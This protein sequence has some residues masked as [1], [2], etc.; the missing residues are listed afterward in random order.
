MS[1]PGL[2]PAQHEAGDVSANFVWAGATTVM[3]AVAFL[4]ALVLWLFPASLL[5]RTLHLPLSP[6][7]A[8]ALQPDPAADMARF[9]SE[10][11]AQLN[12]TG[13][14]DQSADRAHIPIAQAM[15][16]VA[17]EGIRG[18]PPAPEQAPLAQAA[19]GKAPTGGVA[20]NKPQEKLH[21][22]HRHHRGVQRPG[23]GRRCPTGARHC[24]GRL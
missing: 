20:A 16:L 7:P 9:Y 21:E 22:A 11:M 4:A 14:I 23:A 15:R 18:W 13:W 12:S 2:E 6:Y 3:L 1:K 24:R 19:G 10:E 5:D 8:P 17:K